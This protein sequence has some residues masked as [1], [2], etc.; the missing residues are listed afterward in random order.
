MHGEE[1][2]RRWLH[3]LVL[4]EV[5]PDEAKIQKLA[6]YPAA[7][8]CWVL[9]GLKLSCRYL[10]KNPFVPKPNAPRNEQQRPINFSPILWDLTSWILFVLPMAGPCCS[11]FQFALKAKYVTAKGR[12]KGRVMYRGAKLGLVQVAVKGWWDEKYSWSFQRWP[13]CRISWKVTW[14]AVPLTQPQPKSMN[15]F[16]FRGSHHR[17]G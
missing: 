3:F 1:N 17:V 8:P 16:S 13:G 12:R 2:H 4:R 7:H 9:H 5:T 6:V 14:R 10:K 11:G 15:P